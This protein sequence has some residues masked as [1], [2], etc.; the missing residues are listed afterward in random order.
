MKPSLNTI[1]NIAFAAAVAI[2]TAA[3]IASCANR[4]N[5]NGDAAEA[6]EKAKADIAKSNYNKALDKL[7]NYVQAEERKPNPD[8][9]HLIAAYYNI[10]GIY[11]VYQNFAQA[12]EVYEKGYK[13]SVETGDQPMQFKLINNI[14]GASCTIGEAAYAERMNEK[15]MRLKGISIGMRR[16][17]YC[18]NKGFIAGASH[19][20]AA[21]AQWMVKAL[22]TVDSNELPESLKVY[23]Y[24]ELYQC[25]EKQGKLKKALQVLQGYNQLAQSSGQAYLFADCYKGLMRIYTKL[26]DNKKALFYQ[27]EFFRY[28]DSLLNI[29]EFSQIKNR[30][31]TSEDRYKAATIEAQKKTIFYQKALMA[32]LIIVIVVVATALIII[33][34]QRRQLY[35]TNLALFDRNRQL[36]EADTAKQPKTAHS[37][38]ENSETGTPESPSA[39]TTEASQHDDLLQRIDKAMEDEALFCDPDFS[40]AML[41]Q[42]TGSNTSYVSQAINSTYN[43]NFRSFL[44]ERRIK[45]AMKRMM[46]NARFSN[47][48]IQGIS[49]SVG[50]KSVSNFNIAFKKITGMTPS[51]YQKI[52]KEDISGC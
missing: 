27:N 25:Y 28:N 11:S 16:F 26:G 43:M 41:A 3:A 19:D 31:Q 39:A 8:K 46:D 7:L 15:V 5:G 36:L 50:F 52:S 23:P 14:I 1:R 35:Q 24:S 22:A 10:G 48:S 37:I 17:Y 51:L 6:I 9:S 45:V 13:L 44:N 40:M 29:N 49:E 30:Y 21:K 38:D 20:T 4:D 47:Y 32:L 2:L 12:R 34:K 33:A 18:F 42:V